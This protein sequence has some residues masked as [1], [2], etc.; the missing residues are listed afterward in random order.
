[1]TS[2]M[3]QPQ[4]PRFN[5]KNYNQWSIQMKVLY[6]SQDLWDIVETGI[7]EPEDQAALTPQQLNELKDN[8]KKDKKALLFIYQAVDEVIFEQISSVTTAK[9]AWD[10][11]YTSYKGEDKVKLVR[12]QTLRCE[13][14]TLRMKDSESVEDFYNR[15][16]SLV[17]QLRINGEDIQDRRLWRKYLENKLFKF[18]SLLGVTLE[19]EEEKEILFVEDGEMVE[20]EIKNM[21]KMKV[22]LLQEEEGD[23]DLYPKFNA[24]IVKSLVIP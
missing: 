4:L 2:N 1:M 8:R 11:L 13:F 5:G 14:D 18:K 6:E 10:T 24:I 21:K 12:L 3:L 23:Q 7:E 15:V 19:E 17:N 22:V 20:K 16:I 9:E